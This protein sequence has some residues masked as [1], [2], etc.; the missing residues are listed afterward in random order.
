[1][2]PANF[3]SESTLDDCALDGMAV[4]KAIDIIRKNLV[5]I[6]SNLIAAKLAKMWENK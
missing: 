4:R 5:S 6:G 3:I 2:L 1:M